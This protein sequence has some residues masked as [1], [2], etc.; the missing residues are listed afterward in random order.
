M[1]D[2]KIRLKDEVHRRLKVKTSFECITMQKIIENL[3]EQYINDLVEY[4]HFM[5][6]VERWY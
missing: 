5:K 6:Q 1:K 4:E 3:V 2:V